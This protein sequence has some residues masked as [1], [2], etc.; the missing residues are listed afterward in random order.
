MQGM[1]G[2][3]AEGGEKEGPLRK[4]DKIDA[5]EVREGGKTAK[6]EGGGWGVGDSNGN[7][8]GNGRAPIFDLIMYVLLFIFFYFYFFS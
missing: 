1:S 6:L 4:W 2:R 5:V 3:D 7:G 8:N